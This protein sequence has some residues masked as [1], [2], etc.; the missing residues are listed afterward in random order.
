MISEIPLL[1]V[2]VCL[3]I[4][5]IP[6]ILF[7]MLFYRADRYEREPTHYLVLYSFGEWSPLC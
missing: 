1:F 2:I 4:C 3:L 6:G 7:A 5:A